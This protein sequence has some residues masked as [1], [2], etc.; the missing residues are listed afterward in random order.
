MSKWG[1]I[2]NILNRSPK[3]DRVKSINQQMHQE[4]VGVETNNSDDEEEDGSGCAS[5]VCGDSSSRINLEVF[6]RVVFY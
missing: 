1:H 5:V 2:P 3:N 4:S 6:I